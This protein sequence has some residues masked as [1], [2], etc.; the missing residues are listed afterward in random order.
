[1]LYA[2]S[3]Q[4]R[5]GPCTLVAS[6]RWLIDDLPAWKIVGPQVPERICE[7]DP[8]RDIEDLE[9]IVSTFANIEGQLDAIGCKKVYSS[10]LTSVE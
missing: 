10:L 3:G 1:M 9:Q 2:G 7:Y 4:L 6:L 5:C 8:A